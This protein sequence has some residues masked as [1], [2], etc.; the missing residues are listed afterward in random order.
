MP[1]PGETW[2]VT[3]ANS[4]A[5]STVVVLE[6]TSFTV[7]LDRVESRGYP[8]RYPLTSIQFL[9]R[10]APVDTTY[11]KRL[12]E[13]KREVGIHRQEDEPTHCQ[14]YGCPAPSHNKIN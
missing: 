5:C 13:L 3:I 4:I 14:W 11:E 6:V 10:T 2:H 8:S 1:H 9:E 12:A 7:V